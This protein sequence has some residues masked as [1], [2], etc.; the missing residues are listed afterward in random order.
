[1]FDYPPVSD[2]PRPNRLAA[3]SARMGQSVEALR[4]R[5][6]MTLFLLVLFLAVVSIGSFQW[7]LNA[8]LHTRKEV[9]VPD[10]TG[11][12]LEQA[13]DIVSPLGLSLAKEGVEFDENLPA[14]AI[15]RQAPPA[16]LKVREGRVI[17]VTL[18]SGG[19]VSF[20]PELTG[21]TLSDAQNLL[22]A[23]GMAPGALTQAYSQN[24]PQ[25]EVLEQSPAAGVVGGRGQM[26]DMKVSKGPPP[27]GT[28]LMG[29]FVN[30]PLSLARSWAEEKGLRIEA[31]DDPRTDLAPGTVVKQTPPPDTVLTPGQSVQLSV[32]AAQVGSKAS[33]AKWVRYQVPAGG[34]RIKV[35]IVLRDD[36]GEKTVFD[37]TQ[38]PGAL[39]EVPVEPQGPSR[40][41]I[42][43]G[44]V[45]VEE[46]VLE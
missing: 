44:G 20:V 12:K 17:R 6:G 1:M 30:Q 10:V 35:K 36:N 13:L 42:Y 25:G 37:G 41:R 11:K 19:Q 7:T 16:G 27:E 32:V 28:L 2:R 33:T 38:E 21:K 15:L 5:P 29:G 26:V 31:S 34:E 46:R 45:L 43:L 40:V 39:V 14:G 8:V 3:L 9:I 22:R 18:S 23:A 4:R 24:H